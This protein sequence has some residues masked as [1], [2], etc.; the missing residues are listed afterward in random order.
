MLQG[1]ST[2]AVLQMPDFFAGNDAFLV[3][4]SPV[5]VR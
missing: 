4:F 1:H 5:S 2:R 3:V